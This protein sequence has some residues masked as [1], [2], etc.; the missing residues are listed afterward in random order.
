LHAARGREL[1]GLHGAVA[2]Q[3][4]S[5]SAVRKGGRGSPQERRHHG[6]GRL[7]QGSGLRHL[8][9]HGADVRHRRFA[10]HPDA[11]LHGAERQGSTQV[12]VLGNHMDR[13]F[14]PPDLYHRFRRDRSGEHQS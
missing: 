3:F 13:V 7:Y 11:L 14:L 2:I 10:A 12:G 5:R 1:H 9:W 4:Q 6:A 8:F